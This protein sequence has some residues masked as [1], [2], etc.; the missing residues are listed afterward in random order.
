MGIKK[1]EGSSWRRRLIP[2]AG[3]L[4]LALTAA[5]CGPLPIIGTWLGRELTRV[6]DNRSMT[7]TLPITYSYYGDSYTV[8]LRLMVEKGEALPAK[9]EVY[10]VY[11]YANRPPQIYVYEYGAT[12][13]KEKRKRY[14]LR[15]PSL[16]DFDM[17]CSVAGKDL[18]CSGEDLGRAGPADDEQ[19]FLLMR[20]Q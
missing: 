9:V 17:D 1:S 13:E 18:E 7:Y 11:T 8:G 15:I 10:Q 6:Y 3:A 16:F 12:V 4:G 14:T 5:A 20:K 19:T 2:T